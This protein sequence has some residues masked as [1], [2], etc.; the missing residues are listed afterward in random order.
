MYKIWLTCLALMVSPFFTHAMVAAAEEES[1][2]PGLQQRVLVAAEEHILGAP[3]DAGTHQ[4]FTTTVAPYLSGLDPDKAVDVLERLAPLL[5]GDTEEAGQESVALMRLGITW[6]ITHP[7]IEKGSADDLLAH[8]GSRAQDWGDDVVTGL[9]Q[10]L[11]GA[12]V[13]AKEEEE[14]PSSDE[15]PYE[16]VDGLGDLTRG[17]ANTALG[18]TPR[19][20][21]RDQ[22]RGSSRRSRGHGRGRG[23][24]GLTRQYANAGFEDK[25]SGTGPLMRSMSQ[26]PGDG[27]GLSSEEDN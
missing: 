23:G 2:I 6:L 9:Q 13:A 14:E 27:D 24:V 26:M 5:S 8:V 11:A 21:S 3:Y 18:E 4:N 12:G 1:T 19:G 7:D 10:Y 25:P 15:D 16:A 17:V 22:G 20:R